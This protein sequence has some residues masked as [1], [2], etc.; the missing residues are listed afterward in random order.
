M[1]EPATLAEEK[2]WSVWSHAGPLV[3]SVVSIPGF[4]VPLIIML[5][6]GKMSARIR[7]NAVES[8]NFQITLFIA[9]LAL[10]IPVWFT[11]G[12]ISE[13]DASGVGGV[14]VMIGIALVLGLACLVLQIIAIIRVSNNEDFRYPINIR[15][16]K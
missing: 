13:A 16:V 6:K 12:S 1:P 15:M 9:F 8:L 11:F 4:V 2:T 3:A 5:T 7:R 14:L 10:I